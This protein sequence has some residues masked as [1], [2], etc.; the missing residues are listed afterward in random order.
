MQRFISKI[1]M[2]SNLK[3]ELNTIKKFVQGFSQD[4]S[5]KLLNDSMNVEEQ[6]YSDEG[7]PE[8]FNAMHSNSEE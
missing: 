8:K 2:E 5:G 6:F 1:E 3:D 4:K 7:E